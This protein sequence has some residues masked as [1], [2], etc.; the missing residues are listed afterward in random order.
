MGGGLAMMW[1]EDVNLDIFKFSENQVSAVVT[2]SDGFQWVLTCFYE[3]PETFERYKS[4]ALLSHVS[5][6]M[7]GAWMC[8][9]DFNGMLS[10]SEKLSRRLIPPRQMDAFREVLETCKLTNLGFISYPY[11]WNNRRLGDANTKERLDRAVANEAW[12]TKFPKTMVT[13]IISH[14]SDHLPLILQNHESPKRT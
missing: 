12:R 4:W 11:T 13:H 14:S 5:S 10:S 6:L 1:K 8:I 2:E 9:G 3:W 7:D